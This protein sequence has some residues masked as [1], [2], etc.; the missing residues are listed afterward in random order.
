MRRAWGY[1]LKSVVD[2]LSGAESLRQYRAGGG[3]V[4]TQDWY[5]LRRVGAEAD[6][7]AEQY[8]GW[9]EAMLLPDVAYTTVDL[10][11]HDR[12]VVKGEIS[13]YDV[14]SGKYT[15]R[16]VSATS[17]ERRTM[18]EWIDHFKV[19][20]SHYRMDPAAPGSRLGRI[21]LEKRA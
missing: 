15:T 2:E 10:D 17:N 20:M 8:R 12:Y 21:W 16:I 18:V 6:A 5:T 11:Y 7:L 19:I 1:V 9:P 13:G 14:I 3:S 4:R